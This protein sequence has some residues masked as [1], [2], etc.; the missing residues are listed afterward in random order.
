MR[1][2]GTLQVIAA[3]WSSEEMKKE[4]KLNLC[5]MMQDL[6]SQTIPQ[7]HINVATINKLYQN[8][9]TDTSDG[10]QTE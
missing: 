5:I 3:T 1:I 10:D 9:G 7:K 4:I 8:N 6:L 2:I